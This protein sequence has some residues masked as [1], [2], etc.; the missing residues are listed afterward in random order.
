LRAAR[1]SACADACSCAMPRR[2]A[3]RARALTAAGWPRA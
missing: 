3:A 1:R 2:A